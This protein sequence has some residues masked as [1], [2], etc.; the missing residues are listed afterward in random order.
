MKRAVHQWYEPT[1]SLFDRLHELHQETALDRLTSE[2]L[3][4]GVAISDYESTHAIVWFCKMIL[5][6][7]KPGRIRAHARNRRSVQ[8]CGELPPV[9][10][11]GEWQN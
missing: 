11:V 10:P 5:L 4:S 6:W 2:R 9:Q 8:K 3:A 1:M 7:P